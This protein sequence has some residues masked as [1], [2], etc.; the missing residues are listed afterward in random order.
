MVANNGYISATGTIRLSGSGAGPA[1]SG[2]RERATCVIEVSG[3]VCATPGFNNGRTE[4]C[5]M[6]YVAMPI[7]HATLISEV[8]IVAVFTG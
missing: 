1:R 4:G 5:G 6:E 3:N 7:L 2:E 8:V